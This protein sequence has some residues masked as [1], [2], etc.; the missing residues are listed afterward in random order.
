MSRLR[1]ERLTQ[2][3]SDLQDKSTSTEKLG[4]VTAQITHPEAME[5]GY[6]GKEKTESP[7]DLTMPKESPNREP[8]LE[9][10]SD[11]YV[12]ARLYATSPPFAAPP[13]LLALEEP[14]D[15]QEKVQGDLGLSGPIQTPK[16]GDPIAHRVAEL[17]T[18]RKGD[19]SQGQHPSEEALP[20]QFVNDLEIPA[21][22]LNCYIA[23]FAARLIDSLRLQSLDEKTA[24]IVTDI[25]PDSLGHYA[26]M[27]GYSPISEAHKDVMFLVYKHRR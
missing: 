10:Y 20:T 27:M 2:Q 21:S 23:E 12:S 24:R 25:L 5:I 11:R 18:P 13:A 8:Y 4:T 16:L 1:F 22:I 15:R 19:L 17:S 9:A 3:M 6:L 7:K 14:D 26:L